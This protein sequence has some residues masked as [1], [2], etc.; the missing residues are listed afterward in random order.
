MYNNS[1]SE[2]FENSDN[3]LSFLFLSPSGLWQTTVFAPFSL[4]RQA[5]EEE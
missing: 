5:T 4:P 3:K 1:A 2:Y